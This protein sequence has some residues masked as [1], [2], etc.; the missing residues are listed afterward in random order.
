MSHAASP[1]GLF[2][3]AERAAEY[4]RSKTA[5]RSH[6]AIVLG[7]G[8]GAFAD[9]LKDATKIPYADIPGF[10]RS[11]AEG[12]V[13]RLV[14][15]TVDG[16][17]IA[18]M[19]GRVHLYEGHSL[20]D[21]TFPM[22]VF[23]RLG[24]RAAILTNAA[25]GIGS[26]MVPGCLMVLSDHINLQGTNPLVGAN[27]ARF[28]V[29][30][31]DMADA[32]AEKYRS[33]ALSKG[34]KLGIP[35]YE[36]VYAALT[37]PSYETAAEIRMLRTLGADAVGMSTVPEVIVARHMGIKCLAI[38]CITN[39]HGGLKSE[40]LTHEEV[41]D[42]GNRVRGQFVALIK[43]ILPHIEEDLQRA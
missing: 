38:S 18:A 39:V 5:L 17:A 1:Q 42:I 29:R 2:E 7:S 26:D 4:I 15:G 43:S 31:P 34:R 10:P 41:L 12:H 23:G 21:V 36:G 27:D 8:L 11:T 20:E 35:M 25:G 6:I 37:G 14:V 13:G 3:R 22:R 24:I 16:L 28:G 9:E 30:F 19:Q 40:K 32:Y 33:V